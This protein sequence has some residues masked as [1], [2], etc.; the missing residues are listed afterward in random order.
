MSS[1][2]LQSIIPIDMCDDVEMNQHVNITDNVADTEMETEVVSLARMLSNC[3][4][5]FEL[6]F[7]LLEIENAELQ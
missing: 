2:F 6:L 5:H 3:E 4:E 7:S 1:D